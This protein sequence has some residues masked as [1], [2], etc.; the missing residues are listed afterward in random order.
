MA[1]V[2][3]RYVVN[4]TEEQ[5][6]SVKFY[7]HRTT[8]LWNC[9]VFHL[10]EYIKEYFSKT[11]EE[12]PDE[13]MEKMLGLMY[14]TLVHQK[15]F[16]IPYVIEERW[17][18]ALVK[19]RELPCS[20]MKNR[21]SDMVK[22]YSVGRKRM[23]EFGESPDRIIPQTKNNRSSQSI[24][25]GSGEY[26]IRGD[27]IIVH[28]PRRLEFKVPELDATAIQRNSDLTITSKRRRLDSVEM[29]THGKKWETFYSVV[30]ASNQP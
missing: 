24:R 19:I 1:R 2:V 16:E 18:N 22:L 4:F 15:V 25:F 29:V 11:P 7:L 5:K 28:G 12:E 8:L 26:T 14:E 6:E 30:L 17:Q 13:V 23:L 20:V 27:T 21:I 3:N 9:M 10:Q